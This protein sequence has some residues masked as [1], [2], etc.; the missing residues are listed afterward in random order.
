MSVDAGSLTTYVRGAGKWVPVSRAA[1][2]PDGKR[3]AWVEYKGFGASA[4]GVIHLVDVASGADQA[5]NL[6]GAYGVVDFSR[7]GVYL[8]HVI[9]SSDAPM[10]GLALLDPGSGGLK[11]ITTDSHSWQRIAGG[12]GWGTDLDRADPN[13]PPG[14][15]PGNRVMRLDL[16]SGAVSSYF[17]SFGN[18]VEILGFDSSSNPVVAV[19]TSTT[20]T[21]RAGSSTVYSAASGEPNPWGPGVADANGTWLGSPAGII[22]LLPAGGGPLR[23]TAET[24]LR[25]ALV[26]GTCA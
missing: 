25:P 3:Y 10:S 7:E 12:A 6:P 9:P 21:V 15:G 19:A 26:A 20:Y 22:W 4:T 24:G 11:Q 2:S 23:R 16:T 5:I 1:V 18:R 13:P 8:G 14:L 17:T